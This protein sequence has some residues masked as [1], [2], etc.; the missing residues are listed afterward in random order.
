[1]IDLK[2]STRSRRDYALLCCKIV[3]NIKP[4]NEC[5]TQELY[6]NLLHLYEFTQYTR[7]LKLIF[8]IRYVVRI[9]LIARYVVNIDENNTDLLWFSRGFFKHATM[10]KLYGYFKWPCTYSSSPHI[11]VIV[12]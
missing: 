4:L 1:M 2:V 11:I 6:F 8:C 5:Q 12:V 3:I 10:T 9:V 7:D